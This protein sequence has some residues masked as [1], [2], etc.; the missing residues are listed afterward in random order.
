MLYCFTAL[1][2]SGF[3][4]P[5]STAVSVPVPA[6]K[7]GEAERVLKVSSHSFGG[8]LNAAQIA[9]LTASGL[10]ETWAWAPLITTVGEPCTPY[11]SFNS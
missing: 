11:K 5:H 1:L 9:S 4:V 2:L 7:L 3:Y 6:P 10:R 8:L